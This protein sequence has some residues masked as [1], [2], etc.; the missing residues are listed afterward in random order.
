MVIIP[1]VDPNQKPSSTYTNKTKIFIKTPI[2]WLSS[3]VSASLSFLPFL[4]RRIEWGELTFY[5]VA[6]W[7]RRKYCKNLPR[8]KP[9]LYVYTHTPFA[10]WNVR[11]PRFR[12]LKPSKRKSEAIVE[13]ILKDFQLETF[14]SEY[15]KNKRRAISVF[16]VC[17]EQSTDFNIRIIIG[18]YWQ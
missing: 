18:I 15:R 8:M 16:S 17:L 13:D 10:S 14:S 9:M 7:D 4:P 5:W 1:L 2:Y 3:L 6:L 12:A 11:G